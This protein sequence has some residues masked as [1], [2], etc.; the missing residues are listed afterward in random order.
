[1]ETPVPVDLTSTLSGLP[2]E[3]PEDLLPRI[4]EQTQ[5]VKVVVLDDDPTGTQTV[6][7]VPVLTGWSVD[8]LG[9]ELEDPS[10]ALFVL[11]NSRSLTAADACDLNAEIGRNLIEASGSVGREF[12]VVSR[13]DST[14]RGHFPDEVEALADSLRREFH[15]WLVIPFFLEGG[16]YTIRNVHYVAQGDWLVPAGQT[17][18]ARDEAFG[19]RASD[20]RAWVEEKTAGRVKAGSVA[21]VSLEDLRRGGPS[22]VVGLLDG[23]ERGAVC[24]VNAASRRDLE[25]FTAGLLEVEA[26]GLRFLYRTAASFAAVRAGVGARALLSTEE[27]DLPASGGALLVVGSYVPRTTEQLARLFEVPGVEPVEVDVHALLSEGRRDAEIVR[28]AGATDGALKE[29]R[30]V[31]VYTKREL[32][33]GGDADGSLSLGQRISSALVSVVRSLKV[34]PRYLLAKGGITSSDVATDALGVE[35]AEVLG[36]ILPGVPVWRL[37]KESRLPGVPYIVFPGNVG[38]PDAL[39]K[40]VRQLRADRTP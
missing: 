26:R 30:D 16:R 28:A 38:G 20:L 7:G 6:H 24:I 31:V 5:G 10:T 15:A 12:V 21:T 32:L 27:L 18:F 4:R 19:Y 22:R 37:G 39:G 33:R 14:L 1:M 25:V 36:Q 9:K 2:P 13:S 23:L 11:T 8:K 3:W 29:K 34:R 35:R 40:I 17:E